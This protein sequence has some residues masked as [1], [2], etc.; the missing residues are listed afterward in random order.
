MKRIKTKFLLLLLLI[1]FCVF[2][3]STINGV[4]L[5]KGSKQPIPG[6]NI[7]VTGANI[8]TS[9]DFDGKFQLGGLKNGDKVVFSFIGYDSKTVTFTS[10]A[11][12][13]N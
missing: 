3:Q 4:V 7:K 8:S 2:A 1:P 6:V 9:T 11:W 12:R 13:V 10:N 5:E